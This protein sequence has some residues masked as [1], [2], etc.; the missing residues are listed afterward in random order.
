MQRLR[1]LGVS[2]LRL[3]EDGELRGEVYRE[4]ARDTVPRQDVLGPSGNVVRVRVQTVP[5][6]L[7]VKVG[8]YYVPLDQPLAN[9]ALV[10]LEPDTQ[11]SYLANR[12]V[13]SV[14]NAA[15]VLAR[16]TVKTSP[17]P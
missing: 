7:D 10:A 6:L 3:D 17:V 5:A 13:E 8:S 1:A 2:V 16:P 11:N 4:T 14:D 15:R 9:L 12:I